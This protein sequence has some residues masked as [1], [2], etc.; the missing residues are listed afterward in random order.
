MD[1]GYPAAVVLPEGDIFCCFHTDFS[2][3]HSEI[4]GLHLQAA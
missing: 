2:E 3:G 1:C 4:R